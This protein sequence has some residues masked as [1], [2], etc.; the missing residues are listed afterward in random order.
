VDRGRVGIVDGVGM[1]MMFAVDGHP[2]AHSDARRQP[3]DHGE[4]PTRRRRECD[5]AVRQSAME[6]HR[7]GEIGD[8]GDGDP[9]H[10]AENQ[11]PDERINHIKHG[12]DSSRF[13]TDQ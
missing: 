4:G 12:A 7:C 10:R 5:G 6:E 2:L 8:G 11:M 1:G 3:Q 9:D 13:P